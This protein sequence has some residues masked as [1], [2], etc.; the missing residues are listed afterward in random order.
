[1]N[2]E[3]DQERDLGCHHLGALPSGTS[4]QG[5]SYCRAKDSP[6]GGLTG[7]V[8]L[9]YM[10]LLLYSFPAEIFGEPRIVCAS[11]STSST[12]TCRHDPQKAD[13]V[14]AEEPIPQVCRAPGLLS[15]DLS[16]RKPQA[17]AC[18]Q[19]RT[20]NRQFLSQS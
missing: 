16:G 20:Q 6:W 8:L 3:R 14:R 1:M 15:S 5:R 4:S 10:V 9:F 11:I 7:R 2:R 12:T 19:G 13:A 17:G 18:P